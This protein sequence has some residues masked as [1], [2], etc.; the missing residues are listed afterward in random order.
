[1]REPNSGAVARPG[2][3]PDPD[4]QP[5]TAA[6]NPEAESFGEAPPPTSDM[7]AVGGALTG[8]DGAVYPL[9]R[10]YVIGRD[11]MIDEA[12]RRAAASPIVIPR[13][14]HVS[15][16]HARLN[17][18]QGKVFVRDA[19]TPGGTFMAAPGAPDWVRVGQRPTELRPGWSLR[20]G[21]RVLT[22]R[23]AQESH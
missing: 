12:V 8:A 6:Y 20:I 5:P 9:D 21:E 1:M 2:E 7:A 14:R 16:V 10:Q 11:P 22:F 3:R 13:D 23:T 18:E 17:I 19:G 15:R 4:D